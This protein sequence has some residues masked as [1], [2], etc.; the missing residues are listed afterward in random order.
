LKDINCHSETTKDITTSTQDTIESSE[1]KVESC[2]NQFESSKNLESSTGIPNASQNQS[3]LTEPSKSI[4]E[5]R[6]KSIPH[7]IQVVL[8]S[9]LGIDMASHLILFTS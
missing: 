2:T 5:T 7:I 3:D 1:K 4:P 8:G 6:E 9:N